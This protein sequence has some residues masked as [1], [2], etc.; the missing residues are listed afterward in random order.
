MALPKFSE[1][2]GV[3]K[4][5]D[6]LGLPKLA[7]NFLYGYGDIKYL[8]SKFGILI[9][10]FLTRLEKRF[11]THSL[12]KKTP[13]L[14]NIDEVLFSAHCTVNEIT[15][16]IYA[17]NLVQCRVLLKEFVKEIECAEYML[18]CNELNTFGSFKDCL[19]ANY[20]KQRFDHLYDQDEDE[21][22]DN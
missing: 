22:Q 2:F 4:F 11:L 16:S 14:D 15:R 13:F 10:P 5:A 9:I 8:S 12:L 21:D 18:F 20:C 6:K 19:N 1:I 17:K 3:P 7:E